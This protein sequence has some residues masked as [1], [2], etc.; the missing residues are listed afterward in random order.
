MIGFAVATFGFFWVAMLAQEFLSPWVV[1][2][3]SGEVEVYCLLPWVFFFSL[4]L[5]VPYPLM[6][7]FAVLTGF[8]WDA[9]W[10]VP[11]DALDL[12]F[13]S[14]IVLFVIFGTVLQGI[15]PLFRKGNWVLPVGMCG[16]AVFFQ[17]VSQY[18]LLSFRRGSFEFLGELWL[19]VVLTSVVSMALSPALFWLNSR[20]ARRCGYKLEL[21]QFTYRRTYGHP[22]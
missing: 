12:P 17:L 10:Q 8:V 15:R 14:T 6:L 20:I 4:A 1:A 18:L 9:R 16:L 7:L 11:G 22:I 2:T 21:G 13:G 5:A 19:T 3:S